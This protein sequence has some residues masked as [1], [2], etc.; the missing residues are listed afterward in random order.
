MK[1][2]FFLILFFFL[3]LAVTQTSAQEKANQA[4]QGWF[5]STYWSPVYCDG[6][7]VDL[8]EGGE[9]RVHYVFRLFKNGSVLAKE[10]DQIKGT[11][12]SSTGE[13]FK[14]RETDKYKYIDGWELT[15]HYN[16]I[17]DQGSHYIGTITYYYKTGELVVGHTVCK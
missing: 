11:V 17:G 9:I 7:I 15:W 16:L 6:E 4:D 8:L 1:T 12:T 5:T 10:I 14:I 3:G 13:V 2:T